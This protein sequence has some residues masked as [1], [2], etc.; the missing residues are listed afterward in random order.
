MVDSARRAAYRDKIYGADWKAWKDP[1]FPEIFNPTELLLD[2]HLAGGTADRTAL[3]VDNEQYSYREL[4]A[5]VCQAGHGLLS[6][7]LEAENRILLFAN[8]SLDFIA[9]WLGAVRA[10]IVPIVVSDQYKAPMLL[11]FLR[12]T[13]AKALFIDT[14]QI[15]KF[16]QIADDLP[17]TLQQV[18]FRGEAVPLIHGPRQTHYRKMIEGR[19]SHMSPLPRHCNDIAYMFYSGGTTGTAKGITHLVSDFP[20][21]PERH[22]AFWEYGQDDVVHATSKKFFTHGLWPGVLIPLYWGATSVISRLPPI[23]ENVI[24]IVEGLRVTKLITVPTIIKNMM[25]H[26]ESN[27]LRPDFSSLDLAITAS[28]K[29]PAEIFQKFHETFGV[30]LLDSIGSSE[31]TYEWIANRPREFRRGSLGKPVFGVEIR[32]VGPNG[33]EITEPDTDG[34]AWVNSRTACFYYWRKYDKSKETFIGQ[35][36][37]TGDMMYFDEDGFFW[38]S[39]RSDDV[40]KVKGLWVSPIEIEAELTEHDAVLE[41][42]VISVEDSDGLTSPKAFVVLRPGSMPSGALTEALKSNVQQIGGYKVPREIVYVDDLPRT[43]LLKI[44]RR[45]LRLRE[46]KTD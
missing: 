29:M 33:A 14:E 10:G 28:E 21:I 19:P 46:K 43:T 15:E 44:D 27:R 8:D 16:A 17:A 3:I 42:A 9:T 18:I 36:T 2:K 4:L 41:A 20:I 13:A 38:F 32:L 31:I 45:A 11:Y 1:E 39:G 5:T 34:E 30:E 22:G 35:W 24:A 26:V 25:Q 7:G 6:L 37:R 23:P 40:F 12:D